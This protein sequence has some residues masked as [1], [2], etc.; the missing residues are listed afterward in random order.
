MTSIVY[1]TGPCLWRRKGGS[2][3]HDHVL[4]RTHVTRLNDIGTG[5]SAVRGC[6]SRPGW[7]IRRKPARRRHAGSGAVSTVAIGPPMRW[8]RLDS[9][10]IFRNGAGSVAIPSA[11]GQGSMTTDGVRRYGMRQA[12]VQDGR[13]GDDPLTGAEDDHGTCPHA[14]EAAREHSSYRGSE[15]TMAVCARQDARTGSFERVRR[16]TLIFSSSHKRSSLERKM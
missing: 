13:F 14:Q 15:A 10:P 1:A 16:L 4:K 3:H 8:R 7:G 12:G 2:C 5:A 6:W 9:R 11:N